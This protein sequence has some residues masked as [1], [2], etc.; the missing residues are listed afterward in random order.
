MRKKY[1]E[2]WLP[3]KGYEGLYE[4]SNLGNVRSL[5]YNHTKMIHNLKRGIDKDGYCLV[6]LVKDKIRSTKKV[7]RL[8]A[9]A[10]IPNPENKE[11]VGHLKKLPDGTEDKTANEAWNLAW[12]TPPE[13][14]NFGTRS[15]RIGEKLKNRKDQSKPLFQ[16]ST[17]GKLIRI[18]ASRNEAVKSGF[19]SGGIYQC[20]K[21]KRKSYKGHIWSY[22]PL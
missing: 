10:F 21:G 19:N 12:M 6:A 11:Q 22:T 5:N 13:N 14:A 2:W 3:I 4:V 16:Y 18:W 1:F 17:D 8:V 9:E 7:H 20:C 15:K